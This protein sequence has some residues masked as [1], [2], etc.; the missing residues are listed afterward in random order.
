[1]DKNNNGNEQV[2][3]DFRLQESKDFLKTEQHGFDLTNFKPGG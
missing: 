3:K 1:M 2:E